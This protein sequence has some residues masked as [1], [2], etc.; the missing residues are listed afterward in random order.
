MKLTTVNGG[1]VISV[2]EI[3]EDKT[4]S[5]VV[6]QSEEDVGPLTEPPFD[7]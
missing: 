1:E 4:P 3:V 2:T 5:V 6:L 7:V